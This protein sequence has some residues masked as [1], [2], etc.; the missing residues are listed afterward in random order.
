MG[1]LLLSSI[2]GIFYNLAMFWYEGGFT[3]II[4]SRMFWLV[5][6]IMFLLMQLNILTI[7][8]VITRMN[9]FENNITRK[10]FNAPR[11]QIDYSREQREKKNE[12]SANR[13]HKLPQKYKYVSNEKINDYISDDENSEEEQH[14]YENNNN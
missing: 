5:I 12:Y 8:N 4:S 10:I 1:F 3:F 7:F 2:I 13:Y 11:G 9:F 14:Y 6:S